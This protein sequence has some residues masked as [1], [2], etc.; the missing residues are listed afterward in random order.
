[1]VKKERPFFW[2]ILCLFWSSKKKEHQFVAHSRFS[3]HTKI[4]SI[5]RW[6]RSPSAHPSQQNLNRESKRLFPM[7]KLLRKKVR[8]LFW[9][10]FPLGNGSAILGWDSVVRDEPREIV[11]N[12]KWILFQETVKRG[13]Y[14]REDTIQRK[15]GSSHRSHL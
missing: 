3:L 14:S 7:E 6:K 9:T 15:Y 4:I 12:D 11:F 10:I 5:Y 8:F 13:N 1:M 2:N